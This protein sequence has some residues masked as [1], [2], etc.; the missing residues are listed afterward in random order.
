MVLT[1]YFVLSPAIGLSCHRRLR[2]KVLS[3]RSGL[4]NLRRLDAGVE[5]SG[6]HDFAVRGSSVRPCAIDRSRAETRPATRFA[7]LTLPRPPHPVPYVRDDR[8]SAPPRGT[9]RKG[10]TTDLISE[11]QKYFFDRGWTRQ[12]QEPSLICPS[13]KSA[14]PLIDIHRFP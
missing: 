4:Q 11:K 5:A 1:A 7:H 12:K 14:A 9:R 3:A 13:G 10:Y 2:I 8:A 6:P